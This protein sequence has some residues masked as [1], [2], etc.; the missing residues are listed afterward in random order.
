MNVK[1]K[2]LDTVTCAAVNVKGSAHGAL[3]VI[4]TIFIQYSNTSIF[5][6]M[7]VTLASL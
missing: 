3:E 5:Y 4:D 2:E 7:S 1:K 6:L